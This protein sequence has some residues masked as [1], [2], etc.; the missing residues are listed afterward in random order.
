MT[1]RQRIN[2]ANGR[3]FEAAPGRGAYLSLIVQD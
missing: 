1:W 2:A 3:H